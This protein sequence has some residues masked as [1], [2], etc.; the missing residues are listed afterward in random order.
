MEG[1]K[2]TRP[3][4]HAQP[5]ALH[6]EMTVESA[7]QRIGRSCLAQLLR[8]E[9][10]VLA[11]QPEGVHQMRVAVRRLRSAISSLKQFLPEEQHHWV[12]GELR[13]LG[14]TLG[15]ARNIDVFAAELV[16]AGRAGM[17]EE[18]G[19]DD[20]AATLDRLRQHAYDEVSTA[21]LSQRYPATVLRL[22]Q[23]FEARGWR[24]GPAS[25]ET[26]PMILPI[27]KIAPAALDRRRRKLRQRSKGFTRLSPPERHKLRIAAKKLRY[28]IEVFDSL[29]DR[30]DSE[31]F[32]KILKR[33]QSDLGYANDVRVAHE[34]VV[35]LFAETDLRSPAAHAWIAALEVHDQRLA[36]G[37]RKLRK[38]LCRLN[39]ATPFWRK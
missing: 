1:G 39:A 36:G 10:A 38:H 9:P 15:K 18:P 8:N 5:V 28:A 6:P 35:D 4:V 32:V 22:L 25:D 24:E 21:I 14:G 12:T 27:G 31:K 37:E 26:N 3:A 11:A 34:F 29:F 2:A 30:E 20:L 17:P 13:W 16:P 23:W 7:L 19:W 33:L